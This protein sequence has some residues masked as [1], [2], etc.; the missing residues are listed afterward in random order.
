MILQETY[1]LEKKITTEETVEEQPTHITYTAGNV[2]V[3]ADGFTVVTLNGYQMGS[4]DIL[5]F[6]NTYGL[7][8]TIFLH[9]KAT[10]NILAQA[11]IERHEQGHFNERNEERNRRN[12][13][14]ENAYAGN[15]PELI[16]RGTL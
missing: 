8:K 7:E 14:T 16:T 5:G 15:S 2:H 11:K 6:M 9:E 1:G 10:K 12:T 3:N 13:Y 4:D